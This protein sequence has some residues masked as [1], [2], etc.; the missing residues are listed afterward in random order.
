[1]REIFKI[2]CIF[3]PHNQNNTME[4]ISAQICNSQRDLTINRIPLVED[5]SIIPA[6]FVECGI[7]YQSLKCLNWANNYPYKPKVSFAIAHSGGSL[8]IH[9]R[10]KEQSVRAAGTHDKDHVWEDSCV[11]FFC[12]PKEG[13]T[14][15]NLEA[16]CIGNIYAC[17]GTDRHNRTFLTDE[18]Y[19]SIQRWTSLSGAI[20]PERREETEWEL[21]LII[22]SS[23]YGLDDFSGKVLRGNFYKC[24]DCLS[25]PHFLSWAPIG[26]PNP[27]FHCPEYFILLLFE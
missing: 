19:N 9:F 17:V 1:M 25:T 21:C 7:S 26:T 12:A 3:V 2:C 16:N 4:N 11:E 5:P 13:D 18:C 10:V 8:Y 15:I 27:D 22:P 6:S 24:G 23:V 20:T 14:Y